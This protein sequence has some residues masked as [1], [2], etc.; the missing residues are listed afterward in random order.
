MLGFFI[1]TF[2]YHLELM[3]QS[4]HIKHWKTINHFCNPNCF[5][6]WLV[7][8][9]GH[10]FVVLC[11]KYLPEFNDKEAFEISWLNSDPAVRKTTE[12]D[13][14]NERTLKCLFL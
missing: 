5:M 6:V 1:V 12:F 14:V 2:F 10:T 8:L 13:I 9:L 11:D 7:I 4:L 3:M